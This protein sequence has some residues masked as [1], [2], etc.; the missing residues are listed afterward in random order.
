MNWRI[1]LRKLIVQL[2]QSLDGVVQAPGAPNEDR[3]GGFEHGG[4]L[5]PHFD[6]DFLQSVTQSTQRDGDF[7]VGSYGAEQEPSSSA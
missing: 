5:V 7:T 6:D 1:A 2:F 3:D 4:W